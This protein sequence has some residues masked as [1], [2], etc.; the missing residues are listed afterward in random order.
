M[1]IGWSLS[2]AFLSLFCLILSIIFGAQNFK[3]RTEEKFSFLYA[4]PSEFNITE[5][6]FD[7]YL[8]NLFS[9][10]GAISSIAF[11]TTFTKEYKGYN[12]PIIILGIVGAISSLAMFF[13]TFSHLKKRF[14]VV[15]ISLG[16]DFA[17]C[18][19]LIL[20]AYQ[21][22][23][24]TLKNYYILCIV[25]PAIFLLG[26]AVLMVN[27]KFRYDIKLEDKNGAY[28]RK[29]FYVA[30]ISEWLI[31]LLFELCKFPIILLIANI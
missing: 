21:K 14:L 27:P 26:A 12:L 1:G 9:I 7:N 15:I 31:L 2:F 19:L 6:F 10:I 11:Y 13:F 25:I 3:K 8:G 5:R 30:C 4:F 17:M 16:V 18:A 22:Y 28:K 23:S 24:I 20:L 29:P